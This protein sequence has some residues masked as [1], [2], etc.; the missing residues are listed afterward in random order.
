MNND[1]TTITNLAKLRN[2][3]EEAAGPLEQVDANGLSIL[4][5]VCNALGMNDNE[6]KTVLGWRC[7]AVMQVWEQQQIGL[8]EPAQA[9]LT[10]VP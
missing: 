5:D 10:L 8:N 7:Y 9:P 6:R 2:E 3:I 1:G 4:N